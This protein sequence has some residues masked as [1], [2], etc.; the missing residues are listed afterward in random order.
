MKVGDL[1][2]K[3]TGLPFGGGCCP[4]CGRGLPLAEV[5]AVY[6]EDD[7]QR[8][9]ARHPEGWQHIFNPTQLERIKH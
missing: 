3:I 5:V 9:I 8:V 7:N 6:G 4:H 2:R 1:V